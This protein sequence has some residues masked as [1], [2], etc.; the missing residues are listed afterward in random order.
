[1]KNLIVLI[2]FTLSI[3]CCN[4]KKKCDIGKDIFGLYKLDTVLLI[5]YNNMDSTVLQIA[6]KRNWINSNLVASKE[7]Y[8]I[9]S[10]DSLLMNCS[11]KWEYYSNDLEGTCFLYIEQKF[12][13]NGNL[14]KDPFNIYITF[15]HKQILLPF[16]KIKL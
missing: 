6:K 7:I 11:G 12:Y 5:E 14:P 3:C 10:S 9:K 4:S 16:R 8:N 1:M 2:V 13:N 15:N